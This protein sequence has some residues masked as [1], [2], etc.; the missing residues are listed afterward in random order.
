MHTIA[1][2]SG[3]RSFLRHTT[4]GLTGGVLAAGTRPLW[5]QG[6]T[7]PQ[8]LKIARCD[9]VL[10]TG[11]RGYGPWL[12]CRVETTDG[13]VGWGEGTNFPGVQPIAAAIRNL[14]TIVV[15]ESA[16]NI[17]QLWNRM[18]RFLYYNG[19]GGVVL[20]AIS[21]IDMA[22][23]DIVG[24]KLGVPL[25]KL[26]GGRVHEKLRTY[27]NGWVEGL[28]HT[29]GAFAAKTRDLVS[30]GYTGCKLDPFFVTP[31]NREVTQP[32][33]RLATSIVR[34]IRDAGGPDYDIAIDVHGRWDTKSTL[35]ILRALEPMRLFF[36]EEA[37]PPENVAA[38]AE[39]QRNTQ[40]PLA[41]G[42]R[43]FGRQ[44][45]RELL[46][47]Q[48]VR[49]IQPDL[50]RTGG[51]TEGR[52]IA[53]MADTYYIPVA[54]HNPNGPICTL[55]SMHLCFAIPNFL[56]L[57]Y[58]EKDE[59]IFNDLVTGGLR[60]D[61]GGVYPTTAAGIGAN[62]TDDFLRKYKFDPAR[63]DEAE[64]QMFDTVK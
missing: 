38:M 29:P 32:D 12:F 37:V 1:G 7:E 33:L 36:Y 64:R 21:G 3:R 46:E 52:K 45:F 54:P 58:F 61:L 5:A 41:T 55:A 18:Y 39:V 4:L 25:Y 35:E 19:M 59:P 48:A 56:I 43:I 53:A 22:L 31:M 28:E 2:G 20:A 63:T 30:R 62:V 15:G 57:E 9:A 11:I 8:G 16:W 23:Y 34:A 50:A 42:E 60:R 51:I 10:L 6:A 47:Q 24:K 49:I 26:L 27:A 44:G 14:S 40:T 13:V 17:E